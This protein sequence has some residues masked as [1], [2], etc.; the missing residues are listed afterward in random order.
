LSAPAIVWRLL[1]LG[2]PWRRL[3]A[4]TRTLDSHASRL[5][6]KLN[7]APERHFIVNC[8]GV[9]YALVDGPAEATLE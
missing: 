1:G 9:G 3:M 8:W 6:R 4:R 7:G 5:R 2:M